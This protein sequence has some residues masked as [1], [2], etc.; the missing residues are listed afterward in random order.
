LPSQSLIFLFRTSGGSFGLVIPASS[1][2]R[3]L[4]SASA[5]PANSFVVRPA[6][7]AFV[8]SSDLLTLFPTVLA[9]IGS[10]AGFRWIP[11]S[12]AFFTLSRTAPCGSAAPI[13]PPEVLWS[14]PAVA[15]VSSAPARVVTQFFH[16]WVPTSTFGGVSQITSFFTGSSNRPGI[17]GCGLME[18]PFAFS[19]PISFFAV[20][21]L[22]SVM[23]TSLFGVFGALP[24]FRNSFSPPTALMAF[25]IVEKRPS[26]AA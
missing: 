5:C 19:S 11:A 6:R 8:H 9:S 10:V 2:L 18:N 22:S 26:R 25:S 16:S 4:R 20:P 23:S 1:Q 17:V 7:F 3:P 12:T 24:E 15:N 14:P 13:F 21:G